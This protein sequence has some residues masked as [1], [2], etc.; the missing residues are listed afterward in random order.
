MQWRTVSLKVDSDMA[1]LAYM[2]T[3]KGRKQPWPQASTE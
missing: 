1:Q 2:H 3:L